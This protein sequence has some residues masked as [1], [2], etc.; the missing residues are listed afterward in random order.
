MGLNDRTADRQTHPHTARFCSEQWIEYP[1]VLLRVDSCS[2]VR[3]RYNYAH[4]VAD[5]GPYAQD[6]RPILGRHRIDRVRDQIQKHLLQ[7]DP[8]SSYLRYLCIRLGLYQYPV[9]LQIAARQGEGFPD[10]FVDIERSYVPG[11]L[12]QDCSNAI[13][14]RSDTMAI[15]GDLFER[16]LRFIEIGR[17][18]IKPAQARIGTCYHPRQ[19]LFDFVSDRSRYRIPGHEPRLALAT[20]GEERAEQLRV[21]DRNLVEQDKQEETAGK[22]PED[23]AGIPAEAEAGRNRKRDQTDLDHIRAHHHHQPQI[24]HR[25]PPDPEHNECNDAQQG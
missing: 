17:R 13:D 7:L 20:L 9:P 6:P 3:H 15:K 12:L 11:I 21:K 19:G 14:H 8:I 10:E 24:E 23:P 18:A 16:R 25:A 22:Q 1:L 2:G 4:A 5:L